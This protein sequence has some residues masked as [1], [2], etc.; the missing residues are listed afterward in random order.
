MT[1]LRLNKLFQFFISFFLGIVSAFLL[2]K[3][4]QVKEYQKVSSTL[5]SKLVIYIN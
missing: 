3:L 5:E 2:K 1:A 4:I